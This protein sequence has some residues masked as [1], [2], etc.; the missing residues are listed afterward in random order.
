MPEP[1]PPNNRRAANTIPC[2]D[3]TS[4]LVHHPDETGQPLSQQEVS[5]ILFGLLLAGHE[6]TTNILG[7]GLYYTVPNLERFNFKYHVTYDLVVQ[8]ETLALTIG[9][10]FAYSAGFLGLAIVIFSRRDFR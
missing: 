9:Y 4:D 6:T 1:A 10:A 8:P 3:F 7:N 5:T 2:D